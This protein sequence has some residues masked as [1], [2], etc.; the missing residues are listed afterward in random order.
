MYVTVFSSKKTSSKIPQSPF[1]NNQFY[2]ETK[3]VKD[4]DEIYDYLTRNFVLNI[5]LMRKSILTYRRKKDLNEYFI[6]KLNYLFLDIDHIKTLSDKELIIKYFKDQN[7]KCIIGESRNELNLKGVLS[8]NKCTIKSAKLIIKNINDDLEKLNVTG[9]LDT[10]VI[11][12][13]SYQAPTLKHKIFHSNLSG[14]ILSAPLDE[15]E[16]TL[17]LNE[18]IETIPVSIQE[19]CKNKFKEQGYK[20]HEKRNNFYIVSHYTEKKTPKGY[21]WYPSNPYKLVHWNSERNVNIWDDIVKTKEYKDFIKQ[22]NKENIQ[23]ILPPQQCKDCLQVN[24]RYLNKY[25]ELVERFINDKKL[26]KIQS[27]MGTGKSTIIEEVIKQSYQNS[28]RIL[29]ITNRISL[30]DDIVQ[31]Y[32]DY[33]IKHYLGTELEGNEYTEGDSLVCQIDSLHKFSTKYFDIVILDEFST[34]LNQILDIVNNTKP[35]YRNILTKF[36]SLKKKKIVMADAI[37]FEN[38]FDIPE[39]LTESIINTYR[40]DIKLE[41]YLQKDNFIYNIIQTAKEEPI[42]FSSGSTIIIK[43]VQKL[44]QE[45]NI[46]Y[47]IINSDTPKEKRKIIYQKIKNKEP[48]S[49]VFMYSPTITVG[50]SNLNNVKTHFHYDS[51]NSVNVLASLQMIKRTRN[52]KNIKIFLSEIQKYN[53]TDLNQ[54]QKEMKNY[55]LTDEDGDVIGLTQDGIQLSRLIQIDNILENSHKESF[56]QLLKYQFNLSK[57]NIIKNDTKISP[58][59]AKLSKI[60]KQKETE[61]NLSL[62]DKYKQMNPEEISDITLKVFG[63]SKEE[64][65]IKMF[66]HYKQDSI[67]RLLSEEEINKLIKEDIKYPGIIDAYKHIVE[68]YGLDAKTENKIKKIYT[69]KEFILNEDLKNLKLRRKGNRYYLNDT[70]WE[71]LK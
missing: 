11:G 51:G 37:L 67:L 39:T 5:P 1:N 43:I 69:K 21:R 65:L 45:N 40:D 53:K 46:P 19:L 64:E 8:L 55:Y 9:R 20:F 47:E 27:P 16:D 66:E 42:T 60:I 23:N 58:F 70:I 61:H 7:Y 31:K 56:K 34:L 59:V 50:I 2:F 63:T 12:L 3:K 68:K 33:G 38:I 35:H 44:L 30:A 15:L 22:K 62:F 14:K 36:F 28:Y 25:P 18:D 32:Q 6:K 24:E 54:I 29:F 48:I 49:Q 13:A 4:I 17:F 10:S 71:V 52:V 41:F 26:L 57:N